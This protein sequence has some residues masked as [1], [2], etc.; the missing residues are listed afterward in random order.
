MV[1]RRPGLTLVVVLTLTLALALGIGA[2]TVIYSTIDA[3]QHFLPIVDR[4]G[5]V[6]AAATDTRIILRFH[7]NDRVVAASV[8]GAA[9]ATLCCGLTP[10]LRVG[11]AGRDLT[12]SPRNATSTARGRR[13]H[14][15]MV[16]LQATAA[17]ILN[18]GP[19]SGSPGAGHGRHP[20]RQSR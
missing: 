9:L 5:L 12:G 1:A 15:A 14:T 20:R 11:F 4:R 7:V 3:V 19:R 18:R 17:M 10:E 13:L 8:M 16:A 2:T 6:Y